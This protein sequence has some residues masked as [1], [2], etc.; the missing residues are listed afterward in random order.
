MTAAK[1]LSRITL[2]L[3]LILGQGFVLASEVRGHAAIHQSPTGI[4]E[5]CVALAPAPGAVYS[6]ADQQE[7]AQL[8][9]I[10][11]YSGDFALCPKV[12]STSPGT[13]I[14]DISA[15][16]YAGRSSE[17]EDEQ[18]SVRRIT[19][20]NVTGDP[21]SY[22]M[23]MNAED[24]SA[25]FAPAALL[26]YHFSRYLVTDVDVPV[27]VYRSMDRR[28]HLE[29]V[30]LRGESLSRRPGSSPMLRAGWELLAAA[31]RDPAAYRPIDELFTAD[32]RQIFG[33][34]LR[35]RGSRYGPEING[36]RRSGWGAGQ[37]RDF[38]E[39]APYLALRFDGPL[40]A[41]VEQGVREAKQDPDL[42]QSMGT[43]PSPVQMI[44]WM[45]ELTEIVLLDFIFSQ[46]DRVGNIDYENYWYWVDQG[47]V[48]RAPAAQSSPPEKIAGKQP[49]RL[50][51]TRIN[52]NDAGGRLAYANFAKTT[53][54]L[55][56]FRHFGPETYTRL[57][58]LSDDISRGGEFYKWLQ[59]SFGLSQ[60]QLSQISKNT[61]QATATLQL[62]CLEGRLRFDLRP[63]DLLIDGAVPEFDVGCH[64]N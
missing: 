21:V 44:Y 1:T 59:S 40:L 50:R 53:G 61:T 12:F 47:Q 9:M 31:D 24:T 35:E 27:S 11:F 34:L 37:N 49:I 41:A 56:K 58:R 55:E 64:D 28:Q 63:E 48:R 15:G 26:Y 25:T 33:V 6:K 29:R 20:S 54:M 42:G 5:S 39:T 13:L 30:A 43:D 3:N 10:D 51:R 17:F 8:C 36:T 18:C 7:E 19:H 62:A 38:Q 60:A 22:K 23:T 4:A 46:Q 57:L 52:D 16:A 32:R 2:G 45:K 14:Y